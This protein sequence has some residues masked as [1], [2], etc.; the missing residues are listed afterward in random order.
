[1]IRESKLIDKDE[2]RYSDLGF[3]YFY[4]IIENYT[5]AQFKD[6]VDTCF[7]NSLGAYRT[8]FLPL[9]RFEKSE[10]V[11]T[12]NDLIF[13]KQLLHGHVHDPGA[14]MLGGVCG[15]AGVFSTANDLAKI[16]QMYLNGGEYGGKKYFENETIE[17]FTTSPY[18][19][20][21]NRRALGFDKPQMDYE[22]EGPTC[23]CVSGKSFGHTGF[24]GT[25]A[26]TDPEEQIVY[27][28]LSNRI[29]PDQDNG[30]LIQTNIRTDIQQAIY[31]AI[32]E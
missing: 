17:Y 11:P 14:A 8:G 27:I 31:D 28:F 3:Y 22:K 4:K 24:T 25:M 12:E 29:H 18:L 19:D 7:Y 21:D 13:R 20:K 6:Y 30:K 23:K 32:I 2:Y 15:H 1:M 5:G 9:E 16:M 26:W 10:I